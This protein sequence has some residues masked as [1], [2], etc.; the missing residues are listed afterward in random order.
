MKSLFARYRGLHLGRLLVL[1]A[2]AI[3]ALALLMPAGASAQQAHLFQEEI[4]PSFSGLSAIAIDQANGDILATSSGSNAI[5]RLHSDGTPAPFSALGTNILDAKGGSECPTVP[6]DCDRTPQNGFHFG[7]F[8]NEPQIAVDNSGTVTD[9]DIYVPDASGHLLN[10]FARSGKYLGQVTGAGATPLPFVSGVA[11]DPS[12][13]LY[14]SSVSGGK[15]FKYHPSANPPLNADAV[16]TIESVAQPGVL[17]AGIASSLGSLFTVDTTGFSYSLRRL[18]AVSGALGYVIDPRANQL[19]AVDPTSG[20][21]LSFT[22]TQEGPAL[23]PL[24]REYDTSNSVEASLFST[25]E[26]S[27][28]S[29]TGGLPDLSGTSLFG[30]AVSALNG[31]LYIGNHSK[32]SVFGPVVSL[33]D[34]AT[35]PAS[36]T[37]HTTATLRGTVNPDGQEIEHCYFEYGLTTSYGSTVP[38]A[39]SPAQVGS[40]HAP[41]SVHADVSG[42]AVETAYHFRLV[43]ENENAVLYPNDRA[44]AAPHSADRTLQT[45]A[46]PKLKD[47]WAAVVGATKASLRAVINPANDPTSF[48]VEWGTDESYGHTTPSIAAGAGDGDEVLG[49]TLEG[50]APS[51]IYH[52]RVIA[53]NSLGQVEGPDRSFRTYAEAPAELPD[54]RAWERVSPADKGGGEVGT[55]TAASNAASLSSAVSVQASPNGRAITY[56]S[57]TAFGPPEPESGSGASQYL[58]SRGS[59]GWSTANI[60]PRFDDGVVG[61]G[62]FVPFLGFSEDLSHAAAFVRTPPLSPEAAQHVPGLYWRDAASGAFLPIATAAEEPR[63]S[64]DTGCSYSYGGSS[65]DSS[66]FFFSIRGGVMHADDPLPPFDPTQVPS[67]N[68]YEWSKSEGVRLVSVLPDETPATPTP[69]NSFGASRDGCLARGWFMRHAVSTD[70]S[71]AFW[72]YTANYAGAKKP[73]FARIDGVETIQLDHPNT[74]TSG[75]GGEGRYWDATPDGSR[76]FFTAPKKLTAAATK[77]EARKEDLY[78]YDFEAEEGSRL[79][80]LTP[81]TP[82]AADVRGVIGASTDGTYVYFVAKGVL[83]TRTNPGGEAAEA[84]ANNLYAWHQGDGV[85]FVARFGAG[86]DDEFEEDRAWSGSPWR[87]NARV[88]ADGTHLAFLSGQPLTG[89]DNEVATGTA[90]QQAFLQS[91]PATEKLNGSPDCAEAFLYDYQDDKLVCASC[92]P[93]RTRPIGPAYFPAWPTAWEQP[94]YLNG[95]GSRLFFQTYDALTPND[96]NEREDVYESEAVGSGSCTESDPAFDPASGRCVYLIST[97][98]SGDRSFFIDAS[99]D[100]ADTFVSTRQGIAFGDEDGSYDIY[101]ARIGGH[102]VEPPPPPC[103]AGEQC[104]PAVADPP[105]AHPPVTGSFQGPGNPAPGKPRCPKGKVKS[106]GRCV[107][108]KPHRKTRSGHRHAKRHE[109]EA[110]R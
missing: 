101:D 23:P 78:L 44:H 60:N 79:T 41:V 52:Y 6:T 55:P 29:G 30:F 67:N 86:I 108:K 58:S 103:E 28:Y 56:S 68:L 16:A 77:V 39:E 74:G 80:D 59:S 37:S 2:G 104:R 96:V 34:V 1:F 45:P 10:V 99:E 21:V 57:F 65:A 19:I 61:A 12:G 83:D 40:G 95:D 50:L 25:I 20:H 106:R 42:L 43:A 72:T 17:A 73:L 33:P 5:T 75:V 49:T 63:F 98:Q 97:G 76:V 94:R 53:V 69:G 70:G 11:V 87:Q 102:E 85:R 66:R 71:K 93:A 90:C 107:A 13:N 18:D 64:S 9:G 51:T 109:K 89:F 110:R 26:M 88:S 82:E 81:H 62:I 84:G 8:R 35:L 100:G 22:Y 48:R 3:S 24:L 54:G 4:G 36:I 32:I 31:D 105:P 46:E 7:T 38:C 15:I 47:Q 92:S 91:E 14:L 27:K